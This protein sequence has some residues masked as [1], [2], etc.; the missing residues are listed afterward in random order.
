MFSWNEGKLFIYIFFVL[1]AVIGIV[2][3]QRYGMPIFLMEERQADVGPITD[4]AEGWDQN[5]RG[6]LPPVAMPQQPVNPFAPE[7]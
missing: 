6:W 2:W 5:P 3:G 4:S 1:A 7:A